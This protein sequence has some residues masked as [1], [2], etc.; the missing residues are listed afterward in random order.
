MVFGVTFCCVGTGDFVVGTEGEGKAVVAA[1]DG[2]AEVV[3]GAAPA[4]AALADCVGAAA[5][6]EAVVAAVG[7]GESLAV[8]VS[9]LTESMNSDTAP[10]CVGHARP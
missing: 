9:R 2:L 6:G 10:A 8:T 5:A 3:V 7:D 4:G 1:V